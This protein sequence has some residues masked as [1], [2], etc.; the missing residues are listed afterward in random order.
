MNGGHIRQRSPGAFELRYRAGSKTRTETFRGTKREAQRRLRE[1][2]TLV[3]QNRH[4]EDSGRMTVAHWLDRWLAIAKSE[5]AAQTHLSY[6]TAV[7]VH[8]APALGEVLLSRLSPAHLQ[9]FY[10]TLSAG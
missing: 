2:L 7:R 4:P 9:G 10:S 6:E 8:I 3:D 1:L 5:L